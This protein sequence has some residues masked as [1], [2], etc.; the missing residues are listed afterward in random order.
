MEPSSDIQGDLGEFIISELRRR[1]VA[2]SNKMTDFP[3]MYATWRIVTIEIEDAPMELGARVQ[4]C[5]FA[6]VSAFCFSVFSRFRVTRPGSNDND[7]S[8]FFSIAGDSGHVDNTGTGLVISF[9]TLR[10][11]LTIGCS[12]EELHIGFAEH[13]RTAGVPKKR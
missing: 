5:S 9:I 4:G 11:A 10:I 3:R 7:R 13:P 2:L 12:D 1:G 8:F 6:E